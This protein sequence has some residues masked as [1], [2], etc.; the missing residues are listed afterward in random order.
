MAPDD[1][2][3]ELRTLVGELG[4]RSLD[5]KV[6]RRGLPE[7]LDVELW[8]NLEQTGLA[9]LTSDPEL[10]AGAAEVAVVLRGLARYASAVPVAETDLLAGWLAGQAD[11]SL[12]HGPTTVAIVDAEVAR[13]RINGT[14]VDVPWARSAA[15]LLAAQTSHGLCVGM[16][17]DP[18]IEQHHNLAGEPRDRVTF[19]VATD[20]LHILDPAAC[21]ELQCRGRWARCMQVIGAL[22]AAAEL[23][24]L[25]TTQ[26]V[27][28][29]RPLSGFQTVQH[30]LAAMAGQIERARATATLAVAA[31]ADFGFA[32]PETEYAVAVAKVSLGRIVG[33]VTES[34]HQLHGALGVT[35]DH[36]LRLAT[37]RARCWIDEFGRPSDYAARLGSAALLAD[38]PWNQVIGA[39]I[40][41]ADAA[42]GIRFRSRQSPRVSGLYAEDV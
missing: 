36:P 13:D 41:A 30:T 35:L 40:G 12:P 17:E 22:D 25:H 2:H 4:R 42:H 16:V 21:A 27:Q 1:E 11:L 3:A 31:A 9:R 32:A 6:G 23:S 10:G 28:F 14:A 39:N 34:A 7:A 38:D 15:V 33:P 29:G 18:A 26:R 20:R 19:S 8:R 37:L 5:A 24:V